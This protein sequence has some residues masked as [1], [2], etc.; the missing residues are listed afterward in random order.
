[1]E[2]AQH[3]VQVNA[4]AFNYLD[5]PTYFPAEKQV[6]PRFQEKLKREV[7]LGRMVSAAE[8]AEFAAYLCSAAAD[9]FVG[10]VFPMCGGWLQ[11]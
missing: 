3:N 5:N 6:D 9:C 2:L 1:V 8:G 10:Q 7:P 4:N 11:R